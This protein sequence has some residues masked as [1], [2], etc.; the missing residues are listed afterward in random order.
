M[1]IGGIFLQRSC[2][3]CAIKIL[4]SSRAVIFYSSSY[5]IISSNNVVFH[6]SAINSQSNIEY[7]WIRVRVWDRVR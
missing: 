7:L 6:K 5:D 1:S 2:H 3:Y 4:G